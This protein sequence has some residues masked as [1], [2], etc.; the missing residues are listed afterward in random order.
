MSLSVALDNEKEAV[1]ERMRKNRAD[2]RSRFVHRDAATLYGNQVS[3][4]KFPRS[5]VFK[6]LT[7]H[8]YLAAVAAIGILL[9]GPRKALRIAVKSSTA[10]RTGVVASTPHI[11]TVA[12]LLP[13]LSVFLKMFDRR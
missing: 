9:L 6:I 12:Q 3:N 10:I 7:D 2:D 1:L 5:H 4:S 11:L 13:Q 8:P